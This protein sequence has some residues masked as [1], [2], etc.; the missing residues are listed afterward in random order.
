DKRRVS[1]QTDTRPRVAGIACTYASGSEGCATI[2]QMPSRRSLDGL[3][4][5]IRRVST[6]K[7]V[8]GALRT[9]ILEGRLLPGTQL[10]EVQV[11]EGLGVSRNSVREAV[12]ILEG[13]Y[14]V[15]YEMNRGSVVAEFTDE[16]IDDLFAARAVLELAGVRALRSMPPKERTAYL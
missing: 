3:P 4:G 7:Q 9:A 1:I 14:L 10:G 8:A 2:E 5:T 15:R 11:A 13:E 12:R 16:E 6:A